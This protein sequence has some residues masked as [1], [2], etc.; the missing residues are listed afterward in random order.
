MD[1]EDWR[2]QGQEKYLSKKEFILQDYKPYRKDWEHD[3]CEFCSKKISQDPSDIRKAYS[4]DEYHWV[5]EGCFADFK[6]E[7]GWKV[8]S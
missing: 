6:E 7:F 8:K 5:C 4:T 3:H 2:R 1:K